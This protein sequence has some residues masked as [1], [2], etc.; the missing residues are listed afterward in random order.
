MHSLDEDESRLQESMHKLFLEI[1]KGDE[2][3]EF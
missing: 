3:I 1:M 2:D